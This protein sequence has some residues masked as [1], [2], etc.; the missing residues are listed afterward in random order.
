MAPR[1]GERRPRGDPEAGLPHGRAGR[2]HPPRSRRKTSPAPSDAD[3][4]VGDGPA[5]QAAIAVGGARTPYET[6]ARSISRHRPSRG[7][8]DFPDGDPPQHRRRGTGITSCAARSPPIRRPPRGALRGVGTPYRPAQRRQ[9]LAAQPDRPARRRRDLTLR[10][11]MRSI[12]ISA[13]G[14]CWPTPRACTS[15][16]PSSRRHARA[17]AR[18]EPPTRLLVLDASPTGRRRCGADRSSAHW[19]PALTSRGPR[20]TYS[21]STPSA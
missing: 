21:W 20:S 15:A 10:A 4:G 16:T 3:P 12:S 9:V 8:I 6:G 19:N 14:R 1:G 2:V 13:A 18:A 11:T 7:G 17:M 5:A